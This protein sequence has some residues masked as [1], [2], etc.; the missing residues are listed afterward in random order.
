MYEAVAV[1]DIEMDDVPEK[2]MMTC[3]PDSVPH[4]FG[5]LVAPPPIAT[6]SLLQTPSPFGGA[7]VKSR[8]SMR[9]WQTVALHGLTDS[10]HLKKLNVMKGNSK[11]GSPH[12]STACGLTKGRQTTRPDILDSQS[13]CYFP[14]SFR[15]K[16]FDLN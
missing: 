3:W 11:N 5:T 13:T 7:S 15:R 2:S 10:P 6:I 1:I 9:S 12:V 4:K 14:M 16:Y 8:N